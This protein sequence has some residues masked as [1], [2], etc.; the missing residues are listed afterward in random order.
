MTIARPGA[1]ARAALV[2]AVLLAAG[3]AST[4]DSG[5]AKP[6]PAAP[7]APAPAA[8]APAPPPAA[9]PAPAEVPPAVARPQAQKL[10]LEAVDQLQNGEEAAARA[11][12]ERAL[13]LDPANDLARKLSDQIRAD[14]QKEL[15]PVFFRY[16]VQKD[17][18]L[19]KLAQ[20]FLGDRFRFYILAKYNDIANPS[21]VAAGQVIRIPGRAPPP[22]AVTP[23]AAAPESPPAAAAPP[24]TPE[25]P[26]DEAAEALARAAQIEKSG[27][28]EG[29]YAAYAEV[30]GRYPGNADAAKRRDAAKAS[31]VRS[32]DREAST[33]FQRQNLDL[34]IAK[35]DRVLEI[36]PNNK[37]ARLERE[38]AADLKRKLDKKFGGT[39]K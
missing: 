22:G 10:A 18:T 27:N 32:L 25:K 5:P 2:A 38:R 17:D 26:R 3:C 35:W 31:L 8:A 12:I 6:A 39:A 36:D 15:G 23:A 1:A 37:K 21:R 9:E 7:A 33:A 19:S 24:P 13:A 34:A 29:A 20:Q 16:T 11:T 14:A 4:P 30:A 28:L